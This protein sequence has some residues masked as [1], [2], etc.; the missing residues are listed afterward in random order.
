[1]VV[2]VKVFIAARRPFC[3]GLVVVHD[4]ATVGAGPAL[5]VVAGASGRSVEVVAHAGVVANLVR[6]DLG[7]KYW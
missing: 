1:M 3:D 6:Q 5:A 7:V 4:S 2:A